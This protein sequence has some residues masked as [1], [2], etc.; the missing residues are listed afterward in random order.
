MTLLRRKCIGSCFYARSGVPFVHE[1][2]CS[3]WGA[4]REYTATSMCGP[5]EYVYFDPPKEKMGG[6]FHAHVRNWMSVNFLGEW[7]MMLDTDHQFDP[8]LLSRMIRTAKERN[9]GVL[10]GLYTHK[11]LPYGPILYGHHDGVDFAIA[12]LTKGP[13]GRPKDDSPPVFQVSGAG[14]GCLL[15]QRWVFDRIR[16]ELGQPPF[17]PIPLPHDVQNPNEGCYSEDRSFFWRL[18]A[19][20]PHVPLYVD[21]R[22]EC[23]HLLTKPLSIDNFREDLTEIT[24]FGEPKADEP[25]ALANGVATE[26]TPAVNGLD[27]AEIGEWAGK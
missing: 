3:S 25:P 18:R 16:N 8:D 7:L 14:A 19:L 26:E 22:I 12:G 20:R 11:H 10:T 1:E 2:F 4:L 13:D 21:Y 5:D 23:H 9:I 24:V 17:T 6:S 27:L 15:I